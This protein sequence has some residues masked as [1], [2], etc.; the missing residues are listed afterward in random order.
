MGLDMWMRKIE[1][2][3][4]EE[5]EKLRNAKKADLIDDNYFAICI[6]NVQDKESEY[7]LADVMPLLTVI[8]LQVEV[9]DVKRLMSDNS[10]PEG[11]SYYMSFASRDRTA[12]TFNI[13]DDET[14]RIEFNT[15]DY[16]ITE[17]LDYW[18]AKSY[19]VAYWRKAYDVE[20][21]IKDAYACYT[22]PQRIITNC[23]FHKITPEMI[24]YIRENA[25]KDTLED[26]EEAFDCKLESCL[27]NNLFYHEWF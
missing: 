11:T 19:D 14:K 4:T 17:T 25:S 10:I 16:I 27:P 15:D 7:Q 5:A 8:P 3:S 1:K 26:F 21:V 6:Q 23:G 2:I 13:S 20:Y 18:V 22:N 24:K 12:F 9:Y